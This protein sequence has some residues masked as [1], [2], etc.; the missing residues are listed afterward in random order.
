MGAAVRAEV[1]PKLLGA[2]HAEFTLSACVWQGKAI[3]GKA[4]QRSTV[5]RKVSVACIEVA[6]IVLFG[7]GGRKITFSTSW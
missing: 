2:V 3:Q 4:I 6:H 1:N 5:C 7:V